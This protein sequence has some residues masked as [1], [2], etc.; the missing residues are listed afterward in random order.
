MNSR[1]EIIYIL[2]KYIRN[3]YGLQAY[4]WHGSGVS[5]HFALIRTFWN[6]VQ[7]RLRK[8]VYQVLSQV[9][10]CIF[11]VC[12]KW[13]KIL[14]FSSS[15]LY[16]LKGTYYLLGTVLPFSYIILFS[17]QSFKADDY[18]SFLW[19]Y[20]LNSTKVTLLFAHV[21]GFQYIH[22]IMQLSPYFHHPKKKYPI[23][24]HSL[25]IPLSLWPLATTNLF[26]NLKDF[27]V[28]SI[29]CT[30]NHKLC[31]CLFLASFT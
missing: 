31:G 28:L 27:S 9:L 4:S 13:S 30:Q 23:H 24:Q 8:Q 12:L 6:L 29:S 17:Q 21:N 15:L 11:L 14:L 5:Y 7:E 22:K 1:K 18:F 16:N 20:N 3:I 19:R 10:V 25:F 2:L 26:F